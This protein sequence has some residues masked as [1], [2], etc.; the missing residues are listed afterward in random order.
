MFKF[1]TLICLFLAFQSLNALFGS[2][3]APSYHLYPPPPDPTKGHDYWLFNKMHKNALAASIISDFSISMSD[4]HFYAG[5]L[6]HQYIA[7]HYCAHINEDFV[8]CVLFNAEDK[9]QHI[10]GTEFVVTKKLFEALPEEEKPLWHSH[11]YEV[12][13][14]LLVMLNMSPDE[15]QKNY[16]WLIGTYGK[17]VDVWNDG[18]KMPT[19]APQ[20]ANALANDEQVDW[21]MADK[22]DKVLGLKTTHKERRKLREFMVAPDKPA[23]IDLYLETGEIPTFQTIYVPVQDKEKKHGVADL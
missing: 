10:I 22:Q 13:S 11:V 20:L 14:G 9:D 15:E 17:V 23:K 3:S 18:K 4:I 5:N 2:T 1:A 19:G 6:K 16:D 7:I 21:D 8:Q 12:K